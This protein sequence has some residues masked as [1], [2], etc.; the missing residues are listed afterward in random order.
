MGRGPYVDENSKFSIYDRGVYNCPL[1]NY[2]PAGKIGTYR[3]YLKKVGPAHDLLRATTSTIQSM[4]Y[5]I[6][7]F[8]MP[9]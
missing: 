8:V 4:T 2:E 5:S 7:S 9:G 6:S 3:L 1:A